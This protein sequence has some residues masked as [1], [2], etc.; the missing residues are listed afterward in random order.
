MRP[1]LRDAFVS[2]ETFHA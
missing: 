2:R 1:V